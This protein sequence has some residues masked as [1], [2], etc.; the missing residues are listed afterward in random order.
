MSKGLTV[1]AQSEFINNVFTVAHNKGVNRVTLKPQGRVKPADLVAEANK[2]GFS[3]FV[4]GDT[5]LI[6]RP[7]K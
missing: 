2:R 3:H 6:G 1:I 5:V 7:R 4:D